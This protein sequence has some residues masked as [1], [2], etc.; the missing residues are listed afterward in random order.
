TF[1]R[2]IQWTGRQSLIDMLAVIDP[3]LADRFLAQ[4]YLPVEQE[5]HLVDHAVDSVTKLS[6]ARSGDP[7]KIPSDAEKLINEESIMVLRTKEFENFMM[8]AVLGDADIDV[9]KNQTIVPVKNDKGYEIAGLGTP[10]LIVVAEG[11]GSTTRKAMGIPFEPTSPRKLQIAGELAI[12]IPGQAT[13]DS[14]KKTY[15]DGEVEFL[16]TSAISRPESGVNWSVT[17][18][19]RTLQLDPAGLDPESSEFKRIKQ[20][21]TNAYYIKVLSNILHKTEEEIR[22]R[23]LSGPF[24]GSL[25]TS[26]WLQQFIAKSAI[27]GKNA[28]GIGDAVGT[29]HWIVGGGVHVALIMH[30]RRLANLL[31]DLEIGRNKAE[32]MAEYGTLTMKDSLEWG[33]QGIA[34]FFPRYEEPVVRRRYLEATERWQRDPIETKKSPLSY[35]IEAMKSETTFDYPSAAGGRCG[36]LLGG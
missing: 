10:E 26:F 8:L 29:G 25:P 17:D 36:A 4:F 12:N 21:R 16:L 32:A 11:S 33:R 35:I 15:P 2:N 13:F 1:T 20:E 28:V 23:V 30:L 6:K 14:V 34:E 31:F 7:T 18:V 9:R 27:F 24:E 19:P 22:T 3:Q 5:I